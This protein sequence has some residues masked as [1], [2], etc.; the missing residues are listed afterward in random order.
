DCYQPLWRPD[1]DAKLRELVAAGWEY[2]RIARKL[3][4]T[5][6]ACRN[7]AKILGVSQALAAT[8][9]NRKRGR[10][11]F[12]ADPAKVARRLKRIMRTFT[13]DERAVR[14]EELRQRNIAGTM[15]VKGR[16]HTPEVCERIRLAHLGRVMSPE[17][18]AKIS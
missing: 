9:E 17:T 3:K 18:R 6:H 8:L 11:R 1:Q 5:D 4:R 14:A 16:G 7:R 2:A 15:G 10:E 13:P 12:Y